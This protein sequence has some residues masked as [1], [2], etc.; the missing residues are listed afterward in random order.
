M[1]SFPGLTGESRFFVG[2]NFYVYLPVARKAGAK[3][4]KASLIAS[5]IV[6]YWCIRNSSFVSSAIGLKWS[7]RDG[8]GFAAP[9]LA[10]AYASPFRRA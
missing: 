6:Y 9:R 7:A 2:K 3:R 10:G 1:L 8:R 5:M 4:L